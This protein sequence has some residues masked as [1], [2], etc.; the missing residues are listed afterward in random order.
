MRTNAGATFGDAITAWHMLE[1]RQDDPAF[2]REIAECNNY[3]RYLRALIDA[4]P[5]VLLEAAKSVWAARAVRP[6][7]GGYVAYAPEDLV[8]VPL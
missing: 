7:P 3:L 6:V 1:A 8:L 5:G 2:R 4:N